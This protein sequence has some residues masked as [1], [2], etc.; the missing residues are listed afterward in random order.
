[1]PYKS[2]I[3]GEDL[4]WM[5]I[6]VA[7]VA[8]IAIIVVII[9]YSCCKDGCACKCKTQE[10]DI[11][12]VDQ[13]A[14][15]DN[16]AVSENQADNVSSDIENLNRFRPNRRTVRQVTTWQSSLLS[17]V[18]VRLQINR[19]T[20]TNRSHNGQSSGHGHPPAHP[21]QRSYEN[22]AASLEDNQDLY[23]PSYHEYASQQ[24]GVYF[25][26]DTGLY[27]LEK[28]PSYQEA[29]EQKYGSFS[30]NV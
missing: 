8:H 11:D 29:M 18:R 28:P 16:S 7:I 10:G 13:S 25:N 27:E 5:V 12:T 3:P 6:S 4:P 26:T 23:L 17:R 21:G 2:L 30:S 14:I 24:A 19:S 1:M 15:L 20:R 22:Q 9:Y